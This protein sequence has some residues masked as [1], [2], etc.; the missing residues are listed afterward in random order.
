MP[1]S[2]QV[3]HGLLDGLHLGRYFSAVQGLLGKPAFLD[4]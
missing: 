3:H 1:V 4:G 2:V